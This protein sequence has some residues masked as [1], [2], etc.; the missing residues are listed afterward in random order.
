VSTG[1]LPWLRLQPK[2]ADRVMTVF[3]LSALAA[4]V[5]ANLMGVFK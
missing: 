1:F 2:S 3:A 4:T 5:I